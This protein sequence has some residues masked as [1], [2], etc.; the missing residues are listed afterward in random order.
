[1]AEQQQAA[2]QQPEECWFSG[3]EKI[4]QRLLASF[5]CSR[6]MTSLVV[7]MDA[8]IPSPKKRFTQ[9]LTL[10]FE[11]PGSTYLL[12]KG[13]FFFLIIGSSSVSCVRNYCHF[14]I[15]REV[16]LLFRFLPGISMGI[17]P[18][19]FPVWKSTGRW[20]SYIASTHPECGQTLCRDLCKEFPTRAQSR[21]RCGW[22]VVGG[23]WVVVETPLEGNPIS[24][25]THQMDSGQPQFRF[26]F[27]NG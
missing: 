15:H 18:G 1:M 20:R 27:G 8:M 12:L 9:K 5:Y 2:Q 17:F 11:V 19:S 14:K 25:T 6:K 21:G 13:H 3:V 24:L 26:F 23:W 10:C 7:E 4:N 22:W 16:C